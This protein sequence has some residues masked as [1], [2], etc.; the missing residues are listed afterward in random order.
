[1]TDLVGEVHASALEHPDAR[2]PA[3]QM[4][5]HTLALELLVGYRGDSAQV[6]FPSSGSPQEQNSASRARS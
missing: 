2:W 3:D 5:D 4:A 1:M 6:T